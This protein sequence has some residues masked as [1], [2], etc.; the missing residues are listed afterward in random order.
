MCGDKQNRCITP[1][2]DSTLACAYKDNQGVITIGVGHTTSVGLLPD[3]SSLSDKSTTTLPQADQL[4]AHDAKGKVDNS[5][6]QLTVPVTQEQFDKIASYCF[7]VGCG[8]GAGVAVINGINKCAGIAT[9][10]C[11]FI[12][13]TALW[14]DMMESGMSR[15]GKSYSRKL[16]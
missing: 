1:C 2:S 7:N 12:D 9:S 16:Y 14:K 13:E 11:T 8:G 15:L 5:I 10:A 6:Q 3:G 4:L